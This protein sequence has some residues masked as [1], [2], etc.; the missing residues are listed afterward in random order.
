[1]RCAKK[2]WTAGLVSVVSLAWASTVCAQVVISQ[3]NDEGV[4]GPCAGIGLGVLMVNKCVEAVR[5]EGYLK[6]NEVGDTGFTLG[7]G[8]KDGVLTKVEPGGVAAM[9]G[10]KEG[11]TIVSVD[12]KPVKPTPGEAAAEQLFG[13]RGQVVVLKVERGATTRDVSLTRAPMAV[14]NAPKSPGMLMSAK[15]LINWRGRFI[16][17]NSVVGPTGLP[18]LAYCAHMMRPYGYVRVADVGT[19]G[20]TMNLANADKAVVAAVE[21]ES[22]AA[23]AG[24]APG[25]VVVQVDSKPLTGFTTQKANIA[26]FAKPGE[27]RTVTVMQGGAE[28]T[29]KLV[30]PAGK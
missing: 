23:V 16:P 22:P 21:P 8:D 15:P 19:T 7:L 10:F 4:S 1:M 17:C 25:D 30:L 2:C 26:L 12:G 18:V 9:A 5:K 14:Q 11:D 29:A 20:L 28:K 6:H 3:V 13:E 27:T 24:I